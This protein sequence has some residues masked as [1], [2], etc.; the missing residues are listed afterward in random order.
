MDPLVSVGI[1]TY[2]RA[3]GLRAAL[4]R[5]LSQSHRNLEVIISDNG[6]PNGET[7]ALANEL[8]RDDPRIR[9]YRQPEN[10]GAAFNFAFVEQA[11]S[12]DYFM[13]AA[14][15]DR[16]ESPQL[17]ERLLARAADHALTFPN[18]NLSSGDQVIQRSHL[19]VYAGCR[20]RLDYLLRWCGHGTGHPVYG[21]FNRTRMKALG[22]R[23]AFDDRLT[24]YTEGILLHRVFLSGQVSF[25][26]DVHITFSVDANR[27]PPDALIRSFKKYFVR[28]LVLYE[29][30][31]LSDDDKEKIHSTIIDTYGRHLAQLEAARRPVHPLRQRARSLKARLRG[32][33]SRIKP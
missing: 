33:L 31:D 21:L 16:W 22:I 5:V 25:V 4:A 27:H 6:S 18:G 32:Y 3:A 28:S 9:F 19:G 7:E 2:N 17:I 12:G 23:L 20:T 8:M 1:P 30:S 13:W 29:N 11:A 24:Y 15:D 14:D 10:R 26:P